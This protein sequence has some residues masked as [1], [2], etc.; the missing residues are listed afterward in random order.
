MEFPGSSVV[1]RSLSSWA[2]EDGSW[3][4]FAI[5]IGIPALAQIGSAAAVSCYD[6]EHRSMVAYHGS[7]SGNQVCMGSLCIESHAYLFGSCY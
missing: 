7:F 5:R 1:L 2:G 4:A 6:S 3:T